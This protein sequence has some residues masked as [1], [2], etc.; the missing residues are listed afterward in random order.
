VVNLAAIV[1]LATR[2][3]QRPGPEIIVGRPEQPPRIT[4]DENRLGGIQ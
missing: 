4:P 2:V 1:V 3:K